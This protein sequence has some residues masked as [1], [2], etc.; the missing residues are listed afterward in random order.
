MKFVDVPDVWS[1]NSVASIL[2]CLTT[3]DMKLVIDFFL[4]LFKT[5]RD[6]HA[7]GLI[8]AMLSISPHFISAKSLVFN[9][10]NSFSV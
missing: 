2:L 4:V 5:E 3:V 7:Y 6:L 9:D 10:H 8:A 1:L